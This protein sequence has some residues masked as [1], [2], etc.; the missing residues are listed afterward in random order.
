MKKAIT[1]ILLITLVLGTT[2]CS[3]GKK[4]S[5]SSGSYDD[6]LRAYNDLSASYS[7]LYDH[8]VEVEGVLLEVDHWFE[9]DSSCSKSEIK[10]MVREAV[11]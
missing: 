4:K 11:G 2:A 9:G 8:C 7:A 1:I 5:G 10:Q 3:S 6:L